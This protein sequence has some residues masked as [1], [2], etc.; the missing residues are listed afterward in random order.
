MMRIFYFLIWTVHW[1]TPIILIIYLIKEAVQQVMSFDIGVY[2]HDERFCR[3]SLKRKFPHFTETEYKK[4]VQLK[5]KLYKTYLP[6]TNT[7]DGYTERI[8]KNK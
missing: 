8:F 4:I 5:D 3:E 7:N 6:E 2:N 1:L